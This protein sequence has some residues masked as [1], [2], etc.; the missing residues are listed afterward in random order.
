MNCN[1]PLIDR[2]QYLK[3]I[4]KAYNQHFIDMKDYK[5]QEH[6]MS[7]LNQLTIDN[8]KDAMRRSKDIMKSNQINGYQNIK[9]IVFIRKILL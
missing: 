9:V 1:G 7:C 3:F 2:K 8:V 4:H 5:H 6:F